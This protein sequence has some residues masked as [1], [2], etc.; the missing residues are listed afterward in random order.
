M[1]VTSCAPCVAAPAGRGWFYKQKYG[2]GGGGRGGGRPGQLWE[3][4][5]G[6]WEGG[7]AGGGRGA[8]GGGADAD[9]ADDYAPRQVSV[10]W[11]VPV[12]CF[13]RPRAGAAAQDAAHCPRASPPPGPPTHTTAARAGRR[14]AR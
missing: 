2:G 1:N 11:I 3:P 7:Y 10:V 8:Q 13:A 4:Q 9:D 12:H 14:R 5:Q 6:G